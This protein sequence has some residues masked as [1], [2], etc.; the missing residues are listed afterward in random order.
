MADRPFVCSKCFHVYSRKAYFDSHFD[1]PRN[2][3]YKNLTSLRSNI[4]SNIYGES[5]G[6]S[7]HHSRDTRVSHTTTHFTWIIRSTKKTSLERVI[8]RRP[9][10]PLQ[11]GAL[12]GSSCTRGV[13]MSDF[14][15]EFLR[16]F[17]LEPDCITGS[18]NYM[19]HS[20]S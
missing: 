4:N 16:S 18:T 8:Y 17:P 1:C 12:W 5:K 14:I 10:L 11:D 7:K 20:I 2:S 13:K 15:V 19:F 9:C 6:Y 3:C